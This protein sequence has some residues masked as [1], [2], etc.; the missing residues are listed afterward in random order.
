LFAKFQKDYEDEYFTLESKVALLKSEIEDV[1]GKTAD[2][3]RF[4][5]MAEECGDVAELTADTA[6][7][8]IDK[9]VIHEGITVEDTENLNSKGKTR[10][11]RMQE[12][13]VYINCVG[14][15]KQE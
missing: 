7:R 12:V 15:F 3:E 8:F 11:K 6:R 9:I 13:R 4:I 5:K 2:I 10:Q 1:Q 14:E